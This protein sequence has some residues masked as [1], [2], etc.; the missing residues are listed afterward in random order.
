MNS[1]KF[2]VQAIC[3]MLLLTGCEYSAIIGGSPDTENTIV[4]NPGDTQLF[5]VIVQEGEYKTN[6]TWEIINNNP[7]TTQYDE[8]EKLLYDYTSGYTIYQ[9][10]VDSAG[11]Y[12]VRCTD[13][14]YITVFQFYFS[15]IPMNLHKSSIT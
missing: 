12:Q 2:F 1:V 8:K 3:F 10:N 4:L 13:T 7:S 14:D 9:P 15:S 6:T 11:T 5:D